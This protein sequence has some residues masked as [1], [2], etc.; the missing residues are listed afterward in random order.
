M[1]VPTAT[2]IALRPLTYEDAPFIITLLNSPGWLKYIGDRNVHSAEDAL[3]YLD[4][5]PLKSYRENGFGLL[6]VS[7]RDTG[8]P[9]GLCG[10]LQRPDL[11][12]PD[13]GFA[14]L[15]DV[16]GRGLA[17]EAVAAVLEEARG[18]LR[19]PT[20]YAI[21]QPDN[22]RSITL[23]KKFG[24]V[25]EKQIVYGPKQE[26]LDRYKLQLDSKL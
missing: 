2:R 23:L 16:E 10:L 17:S 8:Q 9:I 13:I 15:P 22:K 19:L 7:L 21:V 12:A 20:L 5:G 4:N 3:A 18:T 1:Q 26:T 25:F 14:F 11:G 24:F 6:R